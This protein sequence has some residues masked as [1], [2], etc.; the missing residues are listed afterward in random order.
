MN[1]SNHNNMGTFFNKIWEA[2][3]AFAY[4]DWKLLIRRNDLFDEI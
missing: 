3:N 4:T 2:I 1:K